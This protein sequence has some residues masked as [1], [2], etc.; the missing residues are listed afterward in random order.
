[1]A[2]AARRRHSLFGLVWLFVFVATALTGGRNPSRGDAQQ[3]C[4]TASSLLNRGSLAITQVRND[5]ERAPNGRYYTK[6]PLLC[7]IQ[8]IPALLLRNA[9]RALD[10][11][12][13]ALETWLLA[14]VPHALSATLALA[15]LQL[16]LEL[17]ASASTGTWLALA[18]LFTTPLWSA[19]RSLYS[20]ILQCLLGVYLTLMALRMRQASRRSAFITAGVLCGLAI[21]TKIVLAIWPIAILIDQSRERLDRER[22]VNLFACTLPGVLVGA[23]VWCAYN[24]L[25]FGQW[26][27]QGY[28]NARD[29][30]LG[31]SVPLAS[32]LYG[33]LLSSGKS[34]FAYAPILVGSLFVLPH[35]WRTR[36]RD[37]LLLAVPVVFMLGIT[38]RWWSWGGD[39]AWGPRLIFPII[40]L[41]A[42]PLIELSKSPTLAR[43]ASSSLLAAAGFYVQVLGISVDPGVFLYDAA[44]IVRAVAGQYDP[45][46]LR[47]GL[48]AVHFVPELNPIVAQQWLLT[49]YLTNA[50]WNAGS[51]YPWRSLGIP[52]WRPQEDPTPSR[53]D[54]WIERGSSVA[55][56]TLEVV[57]V[58][59]TAFLA[60]L[61]YRRVAAE[62]AKPTSDR[63]AGA[64]SLQ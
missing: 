23:I 53:L 27:A 8:C 31:F 57:L 28:N 7:V 35:W 22:L 58:L 64:Q 2:A 60:V 51:D 33:L 6:Y 56:W 14:L 55:A 37:L 48:V 34:V 11:G 12:D 63:S 4:M 16:A 9:L 62:N 20:E 41:C 36:R 40:P 59:A 52:S 21:N 29:G 18:V 44:P 26:F 17:G 1:M 45:N 30:T 10:P 19:G 39:W 24:Q 54:F 15:I 13:P 38:A 61:L 42:L 43:R 49:R 3:M 46:T 50:E 32:G 5:V 47:D 25:R